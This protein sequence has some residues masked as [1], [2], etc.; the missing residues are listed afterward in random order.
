MFIRINNI[1]EAFEIISFNTKMLW[2]IQIFKAVHLVIELSLYT[3]FIG[4]QI[5]NMLKT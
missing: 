2:Y 5:L 1:S 4:V 3:V